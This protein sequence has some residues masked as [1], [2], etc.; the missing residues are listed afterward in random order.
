MTAEEY[1]GQVKKLDHQISVQLE[2][3]SS[4]RDMTMRITG[5]MKED[6]VSRT[7]DVHKLDDVVAKIVDLE[8]EIDGLVDEYVERKRDVART[9][10]MIGDQ[11]AEDVLHLHYILYR[12]W[13][14]IAEMKGLTLRTIQRY[15][16]RGHKRVEELLAEKE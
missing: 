11:D 10:L 5:V 1:L 4:L 9:I 12:T 8:K 2:I 7:R 15:R 14:E 13:K 3:L 6:V 16:D